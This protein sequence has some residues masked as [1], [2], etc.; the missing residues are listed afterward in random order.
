MASIETHTGRLSIFGRLADDLT[1]QPLQSSDMAVSLEN[2]LRPA[3]IKADGHFAFADLE[4]S[5]T[6]YRI[7]I[8]ARFY[9]DRMIS[10]ALPT[11]T[12]VQL[13]LTGEDELYLLL[14]SVLP[15][16]NRVTFDEIPFVPPIE[17]GVAVIGEGGFT[18]ILADSL[19][20]QKITFAALSTVAGIAAGQLL[21]IVRSPNLVVRPGPYYPFPADI[22][23]LAVKIVANDPAE[24]PLGDAGIEISKLNATAA[25]VRNVGGLNLNLFNLGGVPPGSIVLDADDLNTATNDRG[26]AVFYFKGSKSITSIEATVTKP[27]YQTMTSTINIVNGTRNFQKITVTKL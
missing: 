5:A 12:A 22:T 13:T 8:G 18:A 26:D 3:L 15:Q 25:T 19:E 7:H 24:P 6:D 10:R 14:G 27:Q 9:Q 1:R 11:A 4:P 17:A 21:R 23:V 20:G 16:Q 2:D